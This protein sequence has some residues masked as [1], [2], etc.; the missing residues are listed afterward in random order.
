M[1]AHQLTAEQLADRKTD[2]ESAGSKLKTAE[3]DLGTVK[4]DLEAVN[5]HNEGH[6]LIVSDEDIEITK[7]REQLKESTDRSAM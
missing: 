7:L 3:T 6:S 5:K 1:D 2:L 4:A